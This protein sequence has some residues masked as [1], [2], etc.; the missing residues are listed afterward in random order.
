MTEPQQRWFNSQLWPRAC[1]AQ[2]W[3]PSDRARKLALV[4]QI[5]G[6]EIQSTKEIG[7]T[8]EFDLV[9]AELQHLANPD[10]LAAALAT[11]PGSQDNDQRKRWLH[12]LAQFD[13][14]YVQKLVMSF[15][16]G[17]T[18]RAEDLDDRKLKAVVV[19]IEQRARTKPEI[20]K[21]VQGPTSKVQGQETPQDRI[22]F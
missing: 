11:V 9:K 10:S 4:S 2:G 13:A 5:L 17:E 14:A 18:C 19:T 16:H 15:S 8:K 1:R 20:R 3:K 6:R 22:P 7:A 21:N 12:K